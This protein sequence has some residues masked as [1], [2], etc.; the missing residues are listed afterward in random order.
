VDFS[1]VDPSLSLGISSLFCRATQCFEVVESD[2][3]MP[4]TD[5]MVS[6]YLGLIGS[7]GY[8]ATTERFDVSYGLSVLSRFLEKRMTR[9][10]MLPRGSSSV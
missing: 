7:I 5:E 6:L 2:F 3:D 9:S 4:P 8:A 10:S 1:L